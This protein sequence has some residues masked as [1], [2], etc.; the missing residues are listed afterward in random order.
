MKISKRVLRVLGKTTMMLCAA[1]IIMVMKAEAT[2]LPLASDL[3]P[4]ADQT[5]LIDVSAE[6]GIGS[7]WIFTYDIENP[8]RQIW[9]ISVGLVNPY[10]ANEV[11][12][13]LAY[14]ASSAILIASA[15]SNSLMIMWNPFPGLGVGANYS[16][17]VTYDKFVNI[18]NIS[19]LSPGPSEYTSGMVTP[20]YTVPVPEPGTLLLLGMGVLTVGFVYR[21]RRKAS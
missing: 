14:P 2:P 17:D 18:Q 20:K 21:R 8:G 5:L 9:Y 1:L 4:F 16:F 15:T 12:A 10:D 7:Q 19:V 3:A 11:Y 13:A 6:P